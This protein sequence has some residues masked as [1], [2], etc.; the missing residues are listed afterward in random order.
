LKG[1][2]MEATAP[3]VH[4]V[5][6]TWTEAVNFEAH[7][8]GET[9]R[10]GSSVDNYAGGVGPKRLLLVALAGCTGMDVASLLPKMRIPVRSLMVDVQGTVTTEHPQHYH[11]MHIVYTVG[12]DAEYLPKIESAVEK[13]LTKYCGVHHMLKQAAT[14]THEI[15]LV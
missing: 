4:R 1:I 12:A 6:A 7:A 13:S 11:E 9:I 15:R 2:V 3:V 5:D 8:G 10:L 14:I